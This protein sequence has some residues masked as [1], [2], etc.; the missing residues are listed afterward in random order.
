M[1]EIIKLFYNS[2]EKPTNVKGILL[3]TFIEEDKI[4]WKYDNPND[5]SFNT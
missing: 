5:L 2:L 4:I 3:S 1:E